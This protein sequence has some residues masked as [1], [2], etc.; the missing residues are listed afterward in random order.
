[1]HSATGPPRNGAATQRKMRYRYKFRIWAILISLATTTAG[2]AAPPWQ[3]HTIDGSS[4]GADGVRAADA[5]GDGWP[6]LATGWEQGGLVRVTLNP[7]PDQVRTPWPAVTVGQVASPE[8]AVM[9]DLDQDGCMDVVSCCEGDN[10]NVF[11]HWAPAQR[12]AWQNPDAW[13]T[14]AFPAATGRMWMF[15][16]PM[17]VDGKHGVDLVIGSK[18]RD[19]CVGWLQAPAHPRDVAAWKFH[20]ICAAGWVMSLVAW[21]M[22]GDGDDDVVVSDRRGMDPGVFWLEHPGP[23][24]ASAGGVWKRNLI[25]A[26][27]MEVMFLTLTDLDQDGYT[28]VLTSAWAPHLTYLRR[29]PGK[30]IAWHGYPI[31]LP[32]N[33]PRGKAVRVAD[34]N[35]DGQLEIITCNRGS[36][37]KSSVS[38]LSHS[39]SVR[40]RTWNAT[41]IGDRAGKKFD[42]LELLDLDRDGDLDVISTEEV[43]NLGVVWYENPIRLAPR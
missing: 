13:R 10:R 43:D 37:D 12:V 5:N 9:V 17:Q 26:K 20:P 11:V 34:I 4:R 39:G 14:E 6:D 2:N 31:D 33:F 40:E 18:N 28:D 32:F 22:D 19:G 23:V 21:D 15:C 29:T 42:L 30:A 24:A 25:G 36:S 27:G 41:E 7:G 35:L 38:F 8:D 16:L 1:M 3:R